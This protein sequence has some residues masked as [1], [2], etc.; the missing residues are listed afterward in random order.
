MLVNIWQA[1]KNIFLDIKKV[2]SLDLHHPL[3][4]CILSNRP[5]HIQ[6]HHHHHHHRRRHRRHCHHCHHHH[7]RHH[8]PYVCRRHRHHPHRHHPNHHIVFKTNLVKDEFEARA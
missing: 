4:L 5:C 1:R 3:E 2:L 7:H 8:H 6:H